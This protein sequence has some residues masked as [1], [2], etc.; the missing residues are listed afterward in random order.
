MMLKEVKL[1]DKLAK[2]LTVL[3]PEN[4]FSIIRVLEKTC[5]IFC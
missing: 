2:N 5:N 3:D 4:T 1:R